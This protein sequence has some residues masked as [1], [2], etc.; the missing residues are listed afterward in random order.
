M[1]FE[2]LRMTICCQADVLEAFF[3]LDSFALNFLS[4]F[5]LPI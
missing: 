1:S 2:S 5:D 3:I 4:Y